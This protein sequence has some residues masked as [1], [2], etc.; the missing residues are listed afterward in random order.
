MYV[1]TIGFDLSYTGAAVLTCITHMQQRKGCIVLSDTGLHRNQVF[2]HLKYFFV[3]GL[4]CK[5]FSFYNRNDT[6]GNE[7]FYCILRL[8]FG[9]FFPLMELGAPNTS[10]RVFLFVSPLQQVEAVHS[11]S[12]DN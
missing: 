12:V 7:Q 3:G 9:F 1:R 8:S 6:R 4:M 10:Y 2:Y 5:R 11:L